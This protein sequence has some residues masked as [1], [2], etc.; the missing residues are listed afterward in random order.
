MD[1]L[2][3]WNCLIGLNNYPIHSARAQLNGRKFCPFIWHTPHFWSMY[4]TLNLCLRLYD[5]I[6]FLDD[7]N[8]YKLSTSDAMTLRLTWNAFLGGTSFWLSEDNSLD[9]NFI[10]SPPQGPVL[11]EA[12]PSLTALRQID[13][14]ILQKLFFL[15]SRAPEPFVT[16]VMNID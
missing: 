1:S 13:Y 6:E 9:S 7:E 4:V 8:R 3:A 16:R 2:D 10:W 14:S 15:P 5:R 12:K 11:E